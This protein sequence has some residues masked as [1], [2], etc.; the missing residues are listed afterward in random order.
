MTLCFSAIVQG[1]I[2][3]VANGANQTMPE[4]MGLKTK[5]NEWQGQSPVWKFALINAI[6][7]L[8]ASIFGTWYSTKK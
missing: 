2:Q 8:A 4:A 6:T 3:A 7:Y 5:D 1:W